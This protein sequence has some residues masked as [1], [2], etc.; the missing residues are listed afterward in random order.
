MKI[1]EIYKYLE[2]IGVLTFS[3]IS[4]GEV[5]SRIA[6]LNGYDEDGMYFRTMK[7][8]PYARQ[9][10]E[11]GKLT[12]CGITDS[13]ILS[14][15]EDGVPKFP[16]GY[17]IR[18]ICE[19][20]PVS[21]E[22]IREKAEN[23]EDLKTAVYDMDHYPAMKEGNFVIYKAKGEIYDFD[24]DCTKRDHK[25]LRKRF[26]FGGVEYNKVGPTITDSCIE[27]GKCYRNCTFK[28]IEK[29][30]PYVIISERCDDCGNCLMNCPVNAIIP[31][32]TF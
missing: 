5:H 3:T 11:T 28:A 15:N 4:S 32:K 9:L 14:H 6:H 26:Q 21:E 24:F 13:R 10:K 12:I 16:T 19:V 2:K 20:K 25:L 29:G 8:K 1:S 27:C 22:V 18:L 17:S 7:N 31:S 30:S 23:N